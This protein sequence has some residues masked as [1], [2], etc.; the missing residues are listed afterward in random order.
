[1]KIFFRVFS[2][3]I[4]FFTATAIFGQTTSPSPAPQATPV[5]ADDENVVKISTTLIQLDVTVTDKKG[6]QITDLKPEEFEIFENG[7]KQD[8]TNFSYITNTG[9]SPE[10]TT[11]SQAKKSN[12][13]AIPIPPIRLKPEQVRRTFAIVID[14]LGLSFENVGWTQQNLRKFI[15]EQ[16]Q[17]G[18]LVAII[19][20]GGGIGA[21]QS[22]TSDKR[23]LLATVDKLR[24]NPQ[25]RGGISSFNPLR[26]DFKDEIAGTT[27]VSGAASN[28]EGGEQD[29]EFQKQIEEFRNENFSAGT[30]GALSY[31]IRGMRELPGRKSIML[32][33]EGFQ[34]ITNGKPN[35]TFETMRLLADLANRSSVVIYTLDPRG[36][37]TPG[38]ATA[39][40]D[41]QINEPNAAIDDPLS[42]RE[43]DFQDTQMSLRYLAYETGGF[44][45]DN[46]NNLSLGLQRVVNAQS[47]YYL[48]GYQPN[49]DTFDPKKNKFNKLVVKVSRPGAVVRYR[50][51]FFGVTDEKFQALPQ[52]P[53]QKLTAALI[54]PFGASEIKLDLY[55]IFYND[56]RNRDFI[57]SLVYIDPSDLT[58]TLD[59]NGT[60]HAKFDVIAGIFDSNGAFSD[61]NINSQELKFSKEQLS[62]VQAKG[63]IYDL[64]VPVIKSGA[65]QF[66][67]AL[68][69]SASG[70]TGAVSQFIEVPDLKKNKLTLSN[71]ILIDYSP[72][73]W[74]QMSLGQAQKTSDKNALLATTLRH[75]SRGT[76][77]RYSYIIYN[78][79]INKSPNADLQIQ[80]RL[81]RDEKVLL[82]GEPKPFDANGQTD[83][84][85]LQASGALTIGKNLAPGNYILQVIVRDNSRRGEI[86]TQFIEFEVVD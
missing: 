47:G 43:R 40:D 14:D 60:Y 24:W 30:L 3:A 74:K 39:E 75:F 67:I 4:F 27:K 1:M 35:R 57:R 17:D 7:G 28:P 85:R 66:R 71:L 52:T 32:I 51:G 37:I 65:Y 34:L 41:I 20:T 61:N 9:A 29:K 10:T 23:Q 55:S 64:P 79:K 48:I 25:G 38:A 26:T 68:R 76:V 77:L 80:T 5:T 53:Q 45:F 13:P 58:F 22:F 59:N 18:D 50:S 36:L 72:E 69:D 21:L 2:T 49:S 63:I 12:A 56:E 62:K 73:E 86:A 11:R 84:Q 54:S 42:S 78:A 46:Q 83:S 15:A 31:V 19:R 70:K 8:I 33:S 16:M 81:I 6:N 44:P 82:E